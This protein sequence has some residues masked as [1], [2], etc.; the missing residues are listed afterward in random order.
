[1]NKNRNGAASAAAITTV[2]MLVV[3]VAR[4]DT[5]TGKVVDVADGDTLT[6]LNEE[7]KSKSG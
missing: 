7:K 5:I 3:N 1:M 2:A 6:V 4:A